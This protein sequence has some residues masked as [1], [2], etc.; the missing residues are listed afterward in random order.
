[1]GTLIIE[2]IEVIDFILDFTVPP[3]EI[4]RLWRHPALRIKARLG[5]DRESPG[6][7]MAH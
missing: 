3:H 6:A 7:C 2:V 1:M 5:E 4:R